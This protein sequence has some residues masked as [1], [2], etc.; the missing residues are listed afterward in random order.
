MNKI[1]FVFFLITCSIAFSQQCG[2]ASGLDDIESL[3]I[4]GDFDTISRKAIILLECKTITDLEKVS[5]LTALYKAYRGQLKY[6]EAET[7]LLLARSI[8]IKNNLPLSFEFRFLLAENHAH[9]AN[10]DEYLRL[11]KP[12][13]ERILSQSSQNDM[14]LGRYYLASFRTA[15]KE[16][17]LSQAIDFLQNAMIH[18]EK[19]ESP[20]IFYYSQTLWS[21]G[22]MYRDAGDFDKSLFYYKKGKE[23]LDKHYPKDHFDIGYYDYKIGAVYYEKMEYQ[24]ALNHFLIAREVWVHYLK[25]QDTYMHYLNEAI[26]DMYWELD[27]PENALTY[28][29][30]SITDEEKI[31][32]DKSTIVISRADS[33]AKSGNYGDALKFYREAYKWREQE[34]GKDNVQT[35]ACKNFVARALQ[36]SGD[37][38]GALDAYQEAISILVPEMTTSSW[39]ANPTPEMKIQSHQ[40][41]LESLRAKG[42]LLKDLYSQSN[43][44]RD[45][46]AALNTQE[47]AISVL[48]DLKNSQLSDTSR[49]FW[50]NRT[51]SIIESSIETAIQLHQLTRNENFLNKAFT[52]SER[53]KAILL[54]ASLY[55]QE[56]YSFANVPEAVISEERKLKIEINNYIGKIQSEENRCADVRGKMLS[57][58]K[59][60]LNLLQTDYDV[61]VKTIELE[62]PDYYK[63]KYDVEVANVT[64]VQK[65]LLSESAALL[66]YFTGSENTYVFFITFEGISIRLLE[67]TEALF[68][69]ITALFNNISSQDSSLKNP[70]LGYE[71]FT[72]NAYELYS[73]LLSPEIEGSAFS[74]LIVIPDGKLCYLPFGSLLTKKP[75][76]AQRDYKSLPYLLKDFSVSYSPSATIQ[77]LAQNNKKTKSA[78][79]GFAPDY[80]GQEYPKEEILREGRILASLNF[81]KQEVESAAELFNGKSLT[82]NAVTED[83]LKESASQAGILHFAMHGEVEDLH[84]M[85]SKLYFNSSDKDDGVLHIYEIFNMNIS[86]QLVILSACNT[87][88][89][90]LVRGEGIV[91]LER[92]FQYAGSKSMLSTLWTVDDASSSKIVA[93]FLKNIKSG[94][95]K[96]VALRDAKLQ[97]L[98]TSSP[99]TLSPFYWSSFKLTGNTEPFVQNS[100]SSYL[101]LGLGAASLFFGV[102][103]FRYRRTA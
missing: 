32:N 78:Y 18:F 87:A 24:P 61:F 64:T 27:D 38:K 91:S 12:I 4:K 26:G 96:D 62:Y 59:N 100:N 36:F 22:N 70:Q 3:T 93:F 101:Y 1:L 23:F 102:L 90:K 79:I 52:Y 56:I 73:K 54:L 94:S 48:E 33:L 19:L 77:L 99:E 50:T 20:P 68:D 84:P 17:H 88:S 14:L 39:Y 2:V 15:N 85:L 9:L 72:K 65:D 49:E 34:F 42:E 6:Q 25:P 29:N 5:L 40:Y 95:P 103:Y 89:G 16:V 21:L 58:W 11:I 7:Q 92:A 75:M 13:S 82:G 30:Y 66:S 47:I 46:E 37:T 98:A 69:Q 28:F 60:K 51:L 8:L 45:L 80:F 74:K 57:L 55:D 63:L 83:L 86:A 81:N 76:T 97:F 53:S 43:D 10:I 35:G 67:K 41:L 31:N 71:Q 44:P